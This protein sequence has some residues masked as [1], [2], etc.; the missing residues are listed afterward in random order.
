MGEPCKKYDIVAYRVD[1]SESEHDKRAAVENLTDG[2]ATHLSLV[3][4]NSLAQAIVYN[5]TSYAMLEVAQC[6]FDSFGG[7]TGGNTLG[8]SIAQLKVYLRQV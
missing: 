5:A 4:Q 6:I 3:S 8:F 7:F 1:D 2:V